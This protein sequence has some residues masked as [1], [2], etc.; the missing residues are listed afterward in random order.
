MNFLITTSCKNQISAL[1]RGVFGKQII[2]HPF[3]QNTIPNKLKTF[4][5]RP[6][7]FIIL[8]VVAEDG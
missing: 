8:I 7:S 6:K 3:S 5:T 1:G 4:Q 2:A